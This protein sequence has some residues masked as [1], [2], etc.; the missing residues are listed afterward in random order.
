MGK[1]VKI[2]ISL[3]LIFFAVPYLAYGVFKYMPEEQ[4]DLN[5]DIG[6]YMED[7]Y[8]FL[9]KMDVDFGGVEFIEYHA[10][11]LAYGLAIGILSF[12][13]GFLSGIGK[14]KK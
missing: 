9:P 1:L 7:I 2:L 12:I 4:E 14:K 10:Y 11:T 5:E 3:I 13:F 6:N 8:G